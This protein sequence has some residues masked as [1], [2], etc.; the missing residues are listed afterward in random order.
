MSNLVVL[1]KNGNVLISRQNKD[2]VQVEVAV[3]TTQTMMYLGTYV[4]V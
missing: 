1:K 3:T 4:E 2:T